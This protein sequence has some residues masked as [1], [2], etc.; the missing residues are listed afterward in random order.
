LSGSCNCEIGC[1][2]E[3]RSY[4]LPEF[5]LES[6]MLLSVVALL[7]AESHGSIPATHGEAMQRELLRQIRLLHPLADKYFHGENDSDFRPYTISPLMGRFSFRR[8]YLEI[9]AGESYWF[10]VTALSSL[11]AGLVE[12][13]TGNGGSWFLEGRSFR[14]PF[15]LERWFVEPSDQGWS[16]WCGRTDADELWAWAVRDAAI[17]PE[18]IDMQFH[19]PTCLASGSTQ[20]AGCSFPLATDVFGG[21]R[22]RIC[23]VFPEM[24]EPTSWKEVLASGLIAGKYELKSSAL[25]FGK[26]GR[27]RVGFQGHCEYLLHPGLDEKERAWLH[28]LAGCSFYTGLGE[29][30]SWGMGQVRREPVAN[31]SY[32]GVVAG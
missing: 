5:E 8:G 26:H 12:R 2:N 15:S 32:R 20:G 21:I 4:A 7:R 9:T 14:A 30:T 31:F 3:S 6:Y 28:L 1:G 23:H 29:A 11:A 24:W 22:R 18:R 10:R 27:S 17:D 25:R 19:S 16:T 13:L